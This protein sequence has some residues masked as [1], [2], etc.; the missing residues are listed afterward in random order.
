[1][2]DGKFFTLPFQ[3]KKKTKNETTGRET[4]TIGDTVWEVV[5]REGERKKAAGGRGGGLGGLRNTTRRGR[6]VS[7]KI[8]R[9]TEGEEEAR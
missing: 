7:Q 4:E 8:K 1:M 5:S 2:R 3:R 6:A 9:E